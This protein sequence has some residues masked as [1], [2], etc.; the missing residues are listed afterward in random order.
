MKDW[1][2]RFEQSLKQAEL[3][4]N[5]WVEDWGFYSAADK[6][7]DDRCTDRSGEYY[8]M[9]DNPDRGQKSFIFKYITASHS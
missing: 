1:Q 8:I 3:S 7:I 5:D 2:R 4:G 9:L 6:M